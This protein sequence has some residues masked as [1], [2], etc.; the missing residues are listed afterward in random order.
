MSNLKWNPGDYPM[1]QQIWTDKDLA[2][3]AL[4]VF[5]V[6]VIVGMVI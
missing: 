6:G 1:D 2:K 5:V 4:I 3:F